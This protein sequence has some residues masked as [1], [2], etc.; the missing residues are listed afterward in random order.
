[1]Y[2]TCYCMHTVLYCILYSIKIRMS[3]IWMS[4]ITDDANFGSFVFLC[5]VYSTLVLP[6][7]TV[8]VTHLAFQVFNSNV[9]VRRTWYK[10][11]DKKTSVLVV[12]Y[13]FLNQR[14]TTC[15]LACY[16]FDYTLQSLKTIVHE[17]ECN[18]NMFYR[19]YCTASYS[20]DR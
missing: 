15:M 4:G 16:K 8:L 5:R 10:T 2:C 7:W 17:C 14:H 12:F 18:D 3:C 20:C 6:Y 13:G 19:K 9:T 11:S 1:M